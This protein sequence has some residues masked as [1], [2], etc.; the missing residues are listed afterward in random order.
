[1]RRTP[2]TSSGFTNSSCSGGYWPRIQYVKIFEIFLR[3]FFGRICVGNEIIKFLFQDTRWCPGPN[4]T[5]AVIATGCASC[6]MLCCQRP[7]CGYYFCYH[8]KAEWHPNQT[9]DAARLRRGEGSVLAAAAAAA[10]GGAA[11]GASAAG[12]GGAGHDGASSNAGGSTAGW[13]TALKIKKNIFKN[14][15]SIV[16]FQEAKSR[17][18]CRGKKLKIRLSNKK[19]GHVFHFP[20]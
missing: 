9:C 11:S 5:Y 17:Q 6:P 13:S 3:I 4:C 10:S 15:V 16:K 14:E 20:P 18:F 8:C 12:G 1:M 7:G 19:K 2:S